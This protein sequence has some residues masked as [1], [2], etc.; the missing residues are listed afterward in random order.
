M[1]QKKQYNTPK[2]T[3]VAVKAKTRLMESSYHHGAAFKEV[4][5]KD[6]FA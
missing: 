4:V 1:N 5:D 6:Y 2:M 3:I